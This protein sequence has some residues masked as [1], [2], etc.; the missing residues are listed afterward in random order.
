MSFNTLDFMLLFGATF[1]LYYLLPQKMRN[2][3][4]LA[5]SYVFYAAFDLGLT[6]YLVTITLFTYFVAAK[7][8]QNKASDMDTAAKRWMVFGVA[9]DLGV[10]AFYKYFNFASETIANILNV[11]VVRHNWL[12]PFGISFI[13]FSTI[14]YMVDIHRGKYAAEK[15]LLKYALYVSFFPKIGQGPILRANDILPQF[16]EKHKFDIMR[17]REGMIMVLYGLF[18]KMVVADTAA[19]VVDQ[20]YGN[21]KEYSGAAIALATVLFSIQLYCDFAG[22]S[23]TA[24]GAAKVL[25]FDFKDNFRQPYLS[26]SVGEFWRRWHISLNT[27]LRDYIY[28]PMGGSR[29]SRA[30]KNLNTLTTFVFSGLWH[31]ADW[32]YVIWGLLNGVYVIGESSVKDFFSKYRIV[33]T[34]GQEQIAPSPYVLFVKKVLSHVITLVLIAFAWIFFRARKLSVAFTAI[35]RIFRN[36][37]LTGFVEYVAEKLAA[38]AGTTLFGLDVVYQIPALVTGTMIVIAVDLI[39]SKRSCAKSLAEGPRALRWAVCYGL[40]LAMLIFGVYGY[41]YSAGSFIYAAF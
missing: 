2:P 25:G 37:N 12:V 31:G 8:H 29:C 38:G 41:G 9:A 28:I 15:N 5:A 24:I 19:I 34:D 40:I 27:W 14:S 13:T 33:R 16:D 23:Y 26:S 18:M 32:G 21:L 7:I 30:R 3:L 20:I 17:Y 22:Y 36:F 39:G 35:S 1:C 11:D 10:L 6:L 4:L